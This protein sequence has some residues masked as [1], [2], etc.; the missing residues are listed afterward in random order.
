M[1]EPCESFGMFS[2][3]INVEGK[4]FPC[5]FSEGEDDW[6]EGIDLLTCTDFIKQIWY[7][8][9]VNKYRQLMIDTRRKCP[10]FD[11]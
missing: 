11:I 6:K 2:C 9:L 5:S 8:P 3:Y 1:A 4:Y 10:I 7:H